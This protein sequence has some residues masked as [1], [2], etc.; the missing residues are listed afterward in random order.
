MAAT[1]RESDPLWG[2]VVVKEATDEA[3]RA[4]LRREA[5]VLGWCRHPGVVE[6]LHHEA[7]DERAVLVVRFC[8]ARTLLD[9]AGLPADQ[10][11]TL[12]AGLAQTLAD[13]HQLGVSHGNLLAE[14]VVLTDEGA[15]VLCG[16]ADAGVARPG[17]GVA[18]NSG[19]PAT[20]GHVAVATATDGAGF[21]PLTDNEAL[22]G[23]LRQ[24]LPPVPSGRWRSGNP[25]A[26]LLDA[27]PPLGLADLAAGLA[28]HA[29]PRL[30][31]LRRREGDPGT[32][33][34]VAPGVTIAPAATLDALGR[35][36]PLPTGVPTID[37]PLARPATGREPVTF[38]AVLPSPA[39]EAEGAVQDGICAND[40]LADWFFSDELVD[41]PTRQFG[42]QPPHRSVA[43][44]D[45]PAARWRRRLVLA[46]V[47][48]LALLV[49]ALTVLALGADAD[50]AP[51]A[52][53]DVTVADQP[54]EPG[55]PPTAA[56]VDAEPAP[57]MSATTLPAGASTT[58]TPQPQAPST[59]TPATP[60]G[61]PTTHDDAARIGIPATCTAVAHAEANRIVVGSLTW[62]L[63]DAG[64]H[65][66][67]ADF[68]C[69]GWLDAAALDGAGNVFV[70]DRWAGSGSDAPAGRLVRHVP[71]AQ[72]L[73]AR[74]AGNG[75]GVLAVVTGA[76]D[77]VLL[78]IGDLA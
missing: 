28:R 18:V 21:D 53:T 35:A 3:G 48:A 26:Q 19:A 37:A 75:C 4:R 14:H 42:P 67:V 69:D 45:D 55:S 10:V 30:A 52:T 63:G 11:A 73:E 70:F 24:L 23:L 15:P 49:G 71:S 59:P 65:A 66:A 29:G 60:T 58:P 6:L 1:R 25:V 34:G 68:T 56:A 51:A 46:A 77:P 50:P 33:P 62:E 40:Q 36:E 31:P 64:D 5:E 47:G 12:G 72:G 17:P 2:D 43:D 61:C 20:G 78:G 7:D 44:A 41:T 74:A 76:A 38:D 54:G 22:T 27:S 32:T 57:A 8:G 16:F 13:L 9:V 39:E